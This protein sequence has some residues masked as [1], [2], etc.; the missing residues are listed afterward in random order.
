M[1]ARLR[2]ECEAIVAESLK[3]RNP[4]ESLHKNMI[5]ECIFERGKRGSR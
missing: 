1:S 4:T 3:G 2:R 5:T